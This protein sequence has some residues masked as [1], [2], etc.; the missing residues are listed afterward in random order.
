MRGGF[1]QLVVQRVGARRRHPE[2]ADEARELVEIAAQK[3]VQL[4]MSCPWHFTPHSIE[5]R[6]LIQSGAGTSS[7]GHGLL[8]GPRLSVQPL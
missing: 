4:L 8:S 5:A 1:P 7:H 3:K 2:L 6:R